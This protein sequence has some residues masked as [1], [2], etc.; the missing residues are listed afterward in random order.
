VLADHDMM[1]NAM[2]DFSH[3]RM[4]PQ[5]WRLLIAENMP[6]AAVIEYGTQ[7]CSSIVCIFVVVWWFGDSKKHNKSRNPT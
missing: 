7:M 3:R 2:K 4:S 6:K 5:Y 1:I